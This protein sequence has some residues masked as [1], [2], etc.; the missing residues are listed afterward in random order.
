MLNERFEKP[1]A[2]LFDMQDEI[3]SRLAHPLGAQLVVAEARRAERSLHPDATDLNFQGLACMYKGGTAEH[4]TQA[5]GFFERAWVIDPRSIRALVRHC[6]GLVPPGAAHRTIFD[7]V[8][9]P[10]RRRRRPAAAP[11][12]DLP[13]GAASTVLTPRRLD[14]PRR[15]P[16]GV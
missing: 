14:A 11:P 7:W 9:S 15:T 8:G 6:C 3:V 12:S 4:L 13:G 10:A 2:N 1:V 5:R 16:V